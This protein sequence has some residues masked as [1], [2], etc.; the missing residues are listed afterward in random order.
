LRK[1][2]DRPFDHALIETVSG[3][4]YRISALEET[5]PGGAATDGE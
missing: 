5:P 4:G 2:V 3:A 1:A